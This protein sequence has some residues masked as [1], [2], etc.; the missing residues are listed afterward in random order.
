MFDKATKT[1]K[2]VGENVFDSAKKVGNTIYNTS[3]EQS[4]IA[5]LKVQKAMV[6]KKLQEYY[7]AIGKRY[8]EYIKAASTDAFD[9]SDILDEMQADKT[10]LE[11]IEE[12]LAEK[13]LNAK[14]AEEARREQKALEDFEEGKAR[15]DKALAMDI[16]TV[17]EYSDKLASIQKKYD[18]HE[19]L[20]KIDMQLQMGIITKEE[21]ELKIE[22]LLRGN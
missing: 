6:E 21:H 13:E 1:V 14:K 8:V 22:K 16:I 10:K 7:A 2:E 4:E 5:G 19:Q 11:G 20:R 17:E 3:K 9:V 12:S 18:N 15:L